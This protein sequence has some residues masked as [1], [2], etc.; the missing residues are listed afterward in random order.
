MRDMHNVLKCNPAKGDL[1][2]PLVFCVDQTGTT[3]NMRWGVEPLLFTVSWLKR[4]I[5]NKR[6]GS[7]WRVLGHMP[8]FLKSKAAKA[9]SSQTEEGRGRAARNCH[10]ALGVLLESVDEANEHFK[11]NK[12]TVCLGNCVKKTTLRLVIHHLMGDGK[13]QDQNSGRKGGCNAN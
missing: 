12:Q 6:D 11:K 9:Q 2:V 7:A 8:D 3:S 1:M 5:R 4:S 10:L 13:S